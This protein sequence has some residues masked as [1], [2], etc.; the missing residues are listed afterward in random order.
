MLLF[1]HQK[2]ALSPAIT[3]GCTKM[4]QEGPLHSTLFCPLTLYLPDLMQT[5]LQ[6]RVLYF[7]LK[8]WSCFC[9]ALTHHQVDRWNHSLLKRNKHRSITTVQF[10]CFKYC[11]NMQEEKAGGLHSTEILMH[12]NTPSKDVASTRV[13]YSGRSV[14]RQTS[15]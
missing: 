5:V 13:N 4:R 10:V 9:G 14:C 7:Y 8:Y 2:L 11:Q 1:L 6:S 12:P 3:A 15:K